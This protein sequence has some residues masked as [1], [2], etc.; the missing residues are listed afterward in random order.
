[1]SKVISKIVFKQSQQIKPFP[2]RT[3]E[4]MG[5]W[6]KVVKKINSSS[7]NEEGSEIDMNKKKRMKHL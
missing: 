4:A 7:M 2:G 6:M 5:G 3:V 1:M